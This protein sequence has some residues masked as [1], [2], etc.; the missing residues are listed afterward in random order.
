M[1]A[2]IDI[3]PSAYES[4]KRRYED[5]SVW[6]KAAGARASKFDPHIYP[7]GSFRL[8]TVIRPLQGDGEYDL[9]VGCR[10]R[11]GVS[12]VSHTQKQLKQLVG[13]DLADYRIARRIAHALS[14]K[15]RC[16]RLQYSDQSSFHMDVV[17]SIPDHA[18]GQRA[19][20]ESMLTSGSAADLAKQVSALSGLVTDRTDPG[21]EKVGSEWRVSN[22]EGYALWFESRML[23]ASAYLEERAMRV[24]KVNIDKLPAYQWKSPLQACIQLLKRHR[25]QMFASEPDRAPISVIITT[26]AA[27][28]YQGETDIS[29]ALLGIV[30]RMGQ[31]VRSSAPRVPNPV[32]PREDFADKW[33][34]GRYQSLKL[35]QAF[36]SWVERAKQDVQI[37][38]GG[39]TAEQIGQVSRARFGV[40]VA[41]SLIHEELKTRGSRGLLAAPV[42]VDPLSFPNRPVAPTRPAGFA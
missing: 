38:V 36:W 30:N 39:T 7:Q 25:D 9:D 21:Y 32:N 24:A 41:E 27:R 5:L 13:S 20:Y 33:S 34:E 4:T 15:R 28:A 37:L 12:R 31:H 23:T 17:P 29:A 18:V 14:E 26:V 42:A 6:F 1:L 40:I 3:P 19:I 35:E 16:W 8:G 11:S 10:L 22:A 2:S